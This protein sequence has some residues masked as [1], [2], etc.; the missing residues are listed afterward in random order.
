[1]VVGLLITSV[2][3]T[4]PEDSL[5]RALEQQEELY[6]YTSRQFE[7]LK[8]Q[9]DI[10]TA[11]VASHAWSGSS[12]EHPKNLEALLS[13]AQVR[14]Q[15]LEAKT[16]GTINSERPGP[17]KGPRALGQRLAERGKLTC[18]LQAMYFSNVPRGS[19]PKSS[20]PAQDA[21]ED[22]GH[23]SNDDRVALSF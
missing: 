4:A 7:A 20:F 21:A 10:L 3:R 6:D 23:G 18:Q 12:S 19:E 2:L 8:G 11:A 16:E 1:M 17:G 22:E 15:H 9:M 13:A 14:R 5:L